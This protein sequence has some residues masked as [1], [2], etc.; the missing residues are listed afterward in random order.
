[1]RKRL[2]VRKAI[3]PPRAHI[4]YY[5]A[6]ENALKQAQGMPPPAFH[7]ISSSCCHCVITHACVGVPMLARAT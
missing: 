2:I 4:M 7:V 3:L 5:A 6:P 1:M